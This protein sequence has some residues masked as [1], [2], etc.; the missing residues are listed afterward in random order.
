MIESFV[1]R[2][3]TMV[4]GASESIDVL[5]PN[6]FLKLGIPI[7][8]AMLTADSRLRLRSILTRPLAGGGNAEYEW[9]KNPSAPL[10]ASRT[11]HR[12]RDALLRHAQG[13]P[14]TADRGV[15]ARMLV[16]TLSFSGLATVQRA[17]DD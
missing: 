7:E 9:E 5:G 12:L 10:G 8:D 1:S 16:R 4:V 14:R 3:T 2:L 13:T 6:G 17:T 11:G 15:L